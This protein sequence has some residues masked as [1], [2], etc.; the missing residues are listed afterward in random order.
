MSSLICGLRPILFSRAASSFAVMKFLYGKEKKSEIKTREDAVFLGN[1][2]LRSLDRW[3]L[4]L[5]EEEEI[6]RISEFQMAA[7]PLII[8]CYLK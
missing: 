1:G 5:E 8:Q 3:L 2:A 6:A 4:R 7:E